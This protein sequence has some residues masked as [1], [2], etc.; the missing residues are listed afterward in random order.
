[1][2]I[3]QQMRPNRLNS[4]LMRLRI[5]VLAPIFVALSGW[6]QAQEKPLTLVL[7]P[8][9]DHPAR[10]SSGLTSAEFIKLME[11]VSL[12]WN[13]GNPKK[14]ADCFSE[15]AQY[16]APPSPP[17]IGHQALYEYFGGAKGRELPMHMHWHHLAFDP[18]GQIGM[19]E[20]TFQY[21]VQTHGVVVVKI[22]NGLITNWREYEIEWNSHGTS[23]SGRIDSNHRG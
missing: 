10:A 23:S 11:Q 20:Y 2:A 1:M 7:E 9:M 22:E 4:D 12:G 15:D 21:R 5:S 13:E 16:S 19:G 6:L 17:R 8:G 18:N 3:Y 14:A